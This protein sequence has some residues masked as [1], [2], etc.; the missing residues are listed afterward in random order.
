[1]TR[2]GLLSDTHSWLYP[3]LIDFFRDC[4]ELWHAGDIGD[5][6]TYDEL[7]TFKP[8]R[9]VHGNIDGSDIRMIC[10]ETLIFTCEEVRVVI[11]HIGGYPGRYDKRVIDILDRE[12]PDLF[13]SG[14][15]HIL[16]VIYDHKRELLHLN[17]GAA[18][19]QGLHS[20]IT[21][22]RFSINGKTISD[23]EIMQ[24]ER[25]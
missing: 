12:R 14:H 16:K 7:A 15:S 23:L 1:M 17:P 10:P 9:A 24:K 3:G 2:I 20:L 19:R 21:C 25:S 13:I 8:L 6:A 4:D 18:G 11:R 5:V 22:I